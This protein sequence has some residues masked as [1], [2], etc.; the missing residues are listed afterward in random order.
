MKCKCSSGIFCND[1]ANFYRGEWYKCEQRPY[2]YIV[3]DNEGK[4]HSF[5]FATFRK[6]FAWK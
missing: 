6:Y 2:G 4:G 3:T 1:G 5:T